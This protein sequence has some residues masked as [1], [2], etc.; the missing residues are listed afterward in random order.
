MRKTYISCNSSQQMFQVYAEEAISE[1]DD[2][3]DD[4]DDYDIDYSLEDKTPT[5]LTHGK[6]KHLDISEVNHKHNHEKQQQTADLTPGPTGM[7][8]AVPTALKYG[9]TIELPE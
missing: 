5:R 1:D 8:D 3:D 4:D 7:N 9:Q 2:N 6:K